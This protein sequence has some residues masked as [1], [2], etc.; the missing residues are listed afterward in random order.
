MKIIFVVNSHIKR[1]KKTLEEI[2]HEFADFQISFAQT[3]YKKH[4]IEIATE[5]VH[6]EYSY[7]IAVGG[8]GTLNEVLNGMMLASVPINTLPVLGVLQRGSANDFSRT[9]ATDSSVIALKN[10]IIEKADKKID[11]GKIK[12]ITEA[13]TTKFF[14]NICGLGLGPE[15]VKIKEKAPKFLGAEFSYFKSIIQGFMS[16]QKKEVACYGDDWEWKGNLLQMAIGN[17][18][19]FGNSICI[20]PDAAIDDGLFHVSL[21]GELTVVDYL[22]NLTKLKKGIKLSH[23][24]AHYFT[25]KEVTVVNTGN[26]FC[27]IEAD[28]EIMGNAPATITIVP[29]AIHFLG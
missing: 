26:Q 25:S 27:G 14:I 9:I 21:F 28:G 7:I 16:Y 5:A 8:D 12:L 4:A 15:A 3:Q 13:D 22:K 18:R 17:G 19:F 29:K 23:D 10:K 20:C 11:V 1:L 24:D 6:N 2:R